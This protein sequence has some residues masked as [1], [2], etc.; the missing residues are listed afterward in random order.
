MSCSKVFSGDLPELIYKIIKYFQN[1]F[2]S[3]HSCIL[4]NRLWCRLATPLLW[5]DPFSIPTKNFYFIEIYLHNLNDDDLKTKLDEYKI[6]DDLLPSNTLFN[7]PS[8]IKYLNTWKVISSIESWI[9]STEV[10]GTLTTEKKPSSSYFIQDSNTNLYDFIR[11]INKLLFK[12]FIENKVSLYTLDIEILARYRDY[13]NDVLELILQNP[14]F[15]CNIKKLYIGYFSYSVDE[16]TLTKKY[17]SQIINLQK[18]LKKI[19]FGR[20][21]FPFYQSSLLSLKD[22][23]CSNT[24]NTIMFY[25]VDFKNVINLNEVFEQLNVLESVHITFCFSLNAHIIQQFINLTK[26][27]KLKSLLIGEIVQVEPYQLLLQKFG[28]YIENFGL[29]SYDQLLNENFFQ[30]IIKYCRKIKYLFLNLRGFRNQQIIYSALNLIEN[31]KQNLNN[32]LINA[33][34]NFQYSS[35]ILQNLGQTLPFKLEYLSLNLLHIKVSEFEVF[36]KN[37]Q[38]TFIRKLLVYNG[39]GEDILPHIRKYIMKKKRIDYLAIMNAF[40]ISPCVIKGEDLFFL[41]DKVKEFKLHNIRVQKYDDLYVTPYN[42][43]KELD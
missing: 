19:S 21:I 18:N 6:N 8:F 5:E 39:V 26:P 25:Y 14:N 13:C 23:N 15:V 10:V 27:F 24:L 32:L 30:L 37:S 22:S 9:S 29:G 40:R 42:F 1:D 11:F 35:I 41:K 12:I 38:N 43:I 33:S 17:L 2:S 7:Y 20:K 3:L 31:N 4:V 34:D 36:L 16:N 28:D